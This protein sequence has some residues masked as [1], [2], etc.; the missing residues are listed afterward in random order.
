MLHSLL[1]PILR[2]I[3]LLICYTSLVFACDTDNFYRTKAMMQA[4]S[5]H[6]F[7]TTSHHLA[8]NIE[9]DTTKEFV[10][11]L[12][13]RFPNNHKEYK[14]LVDVASPTV[15]ST[16]LAKILHIQ[17]EISFTDDSYETKPT[18]Q[19]ATLKNIEI[20]TIQWQNIAVV[21][22]TL[23]EKYDG[24][25][26]ANLMQHSIWEFNPITKNI[27]IHQQKPDLKGFR[28]FP[29]VR[30]IY[31]IP[32][33]HAFFNQFKQ[34]QVFHLS[35]GMSKGVKIPL[36]EW[37]RSIWL[38]FDSI[39]SPLIT[40]EICFDNF[41]IQKEKKQAISYIDSVYATKLPLLRIDTVK[42][43]NL[44]AIVGQGNA[45]FVGNAFWKNFILIIDW[46]ERKFY[47]K[48]I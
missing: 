47:L 26:G 43:Q 7:T 3:F 32:K 34:K 38:G 37:Q 29:F 39:H 17:T 5:M 14:F 27:T 23:P 13:V 41:L 22:D 16:K 12:K 35:T 6:N 46:K 8:A 33:F 30:N 20:A 44:P 19:I 31:R 24:I 25:I 10:Y 40:N 36:I 42:I 45:W 28:A 18:L 1:S 4:G 48:R 9:L 21:I 2:Y 15:I 11:Y